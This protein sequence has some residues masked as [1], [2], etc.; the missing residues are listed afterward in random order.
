M[1]EA[2]EALAPVFK[3]DSVFQQVMVL[4]L[5]FPHGQPG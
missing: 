3:P 4:E 2:C 5:A 1:G